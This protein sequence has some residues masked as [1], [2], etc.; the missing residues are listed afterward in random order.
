VVLDV[1]VVVLVQKEEGMYSHPVADTVVAE[2]LETTWIGVL[3]M[4]EEA[5]AMDTARM[6][7]VAAAA[8][9]IDFGCCTTEAWKQHVCHS[10]SYHSWTMP[11]DAPHVERVDD[12]VVVVADEAMHNQLV[13]VEIVVVVVVA[14]IDAAE[15][16]EA[17]EAS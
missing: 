4:K 6:E 3:N 7:A 14:E 11:N 16:L 15:A 12:T 5:A 2:I 13:E 8:D 1:V 9:W 17:L 10:V